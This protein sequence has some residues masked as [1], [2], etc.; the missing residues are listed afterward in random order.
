MCTRSGL[1]WSGLVW[2]WV[3]VWVRVRVRVWVGWL[4]GLLGWVGLGWFFN[5]NKRYCTLE[6]YQRTGTY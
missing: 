5:V 6:L 2:V 4:V 3:W 1:V